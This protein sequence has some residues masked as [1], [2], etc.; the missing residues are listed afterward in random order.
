MLS[1]LLMTSIMARIGLSA[2]ET[3]AHMVLACVSRGAWI[4]DVLNGHNSAAPVRMDLR[5]GRGN[6]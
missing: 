6:S 4:V 3:M 5:D 2:K 1:L